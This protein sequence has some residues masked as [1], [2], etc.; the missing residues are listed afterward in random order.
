MCARARVH[1][2]KSSK[3]QG[4]MVID[5]PNNSLLKINTGSMT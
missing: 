5:L 2:N 4:L 3:L 1:T